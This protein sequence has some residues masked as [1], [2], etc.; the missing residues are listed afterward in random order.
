MRRQFVIFCACGGIAAFANLGTRW[1]LSHVMSYSAAIVLA[2]FVGMA[3]GY[4]LFKIFVFGS[5]H[6]GRSFTEMV[7]YAVVNLIA[8]VLVYGFSMFFRWLFLKIGPLAPH[9]EDY[10]HFI[11]VMVPAISSYILHKYW[12]FSQGRSRPQPVSADNASDDAD[13]RE[14][15][16]SQKTPKPDVA[17][18]PQTAERKEAQNARKPEGSQKPQD[19]E[20]T[21]E[22]KDNEKL[23]GSNE[24]ESPE[25]AAGPKESH[26][27]KGTVKPKEPN[28]LKSLSETKGVDELK[29]H[30]KLNAPGKPESPKELNN[31]CAGLNAGGADQAEDEEAHAQ[32]HP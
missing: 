1:G 31:P 20:L 28:E 10:A 26:E 8:L 22:P 25:G 12:T 21:K 5:A 3:T 16:A 6:S 27:P 11:G 17:A 13:V 30:K 4:L 23:K 7:R 9:A 32:R 24:P 29:K 15:L 14:M 18:A 2:Y 19:P